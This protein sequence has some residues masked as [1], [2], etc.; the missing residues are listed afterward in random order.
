MKNNRVCSIVLNGISRDARVLKQAKTLASSGYLVHVI[1]IKD[2]FYSTASEQ[3]N[4]NL[5]FKRLNLD[6]Y[7]K[8]I[9]MSLIFFLLISINIIFYYYPNTSHLFSLILLFPALKLWKTIER[10][11]ITDSEQKQRPFTLYKLVLAIQAYITSIGKKFWM[12][13]RLFPFVVTIL[14]IRPAVV[15]CHDIHTLP[16]GLL[17]KFLM[18]CTL[19][20]DAHE[21][22]E[23]V[24]QVLL[25]NGH[26]LKSYKRTHSF[27]QRF[28]DKFITINSSVAEWYAQKYPKLPAATVV[29]N[30]TIISPFFEYDG[31]L[32]QAAGLARDVNVLL[33]QGGFSLHRGLH[34][35]IKSAEYLPSNWVL[36]M[37]GWGGYEGELKSLAYEINQKALASGRSEVVKFIPPAPQ[38]ELV[39]WT[40]GG[41]IGIVPY[42]NTG[43]NHWFCTPNKLWEFPNAGLPLIV[44]PFPELRRPI[45][46]FK[47]GWVMPADEDVSFIGNLI[48]GLSQADINQASLNS[49]AF[50]ESNNWNLYEKKL[51]ELYAGL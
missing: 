11:A 51:L 9:K 8:S 20:Y 21:I 4:E 29:M 1:G 23:E 3:V 42:E 40:A 43:L 10:Q 31:R 48:A 5:I 33:Y 22:Y 15:H 39:Q 36:V 34:N 47:N 16:I 41:T 13:V 6:Q 37:M 7:R 2:E 12:L 49:R 35:L 30:A 38:S 18:P 46:E 45:D 25:E 14:K 19:I 32:H 24:P 26:R 44:S 17:V 27:A 50:I 28:I